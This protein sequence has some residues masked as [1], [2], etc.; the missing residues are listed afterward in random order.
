MP[1]PI[2]PPPSTGGIPGPLPPMGVPQPMMPPPPVL[3][4]ASPREDNL[5]DDE[6]DDLLGDLYD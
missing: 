5:T 6:K 2:P 3:V 4:Q 1:A